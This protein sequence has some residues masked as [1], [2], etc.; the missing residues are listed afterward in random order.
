MPIEIGYTGNLI[1]PSSGMVQ[2][3]PNP[4]V[5]VVPETGIVAIDTGQMIYLPHRAICSLVPNTKLFRTRGLIVIPDL[6]TGP[7]R[8]EVGTEI[9]H[10]IIV[11]GFNPHEYD[12]NLVRGDPLCYLVFGQ[13]RPVKLTRRGKS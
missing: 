7:S 3:I 10:R 1:I 11:T 2:S 9:E 4:K 6:Y 8:E 5:I 12:I 13:T